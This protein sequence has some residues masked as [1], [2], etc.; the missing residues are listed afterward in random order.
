MEKDLCFS[1]CFDMDTTHN[2]NPLRVETG[3]AQWSCFDCS[4]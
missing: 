4:V 3:L 1:S 2:F